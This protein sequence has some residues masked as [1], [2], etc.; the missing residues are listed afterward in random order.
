MFHI[1]FA[2]RR[3]WPLQLFPHAQCLD[4]AIDLD[5][6]PCH[7]RRLVIPLYHTLG[8]ITGKIQHALAQVPVLFITLFPPPGSLN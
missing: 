3:T 2:V 8:I 1:S 7:Y 6:L 4:L 5:H